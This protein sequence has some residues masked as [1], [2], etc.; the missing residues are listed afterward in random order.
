MSSVLS[1]TS[2]SVLADNFQRLCFMQVEPLNQVRVV[3][4]TLH[5]GMVTSRCLLQ[6][7]KLGRATLN[8]LVS[9]NT[10]TL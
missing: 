2:G 8:V 5:V 1:K 9:T 10:L 6:F 7:T 4:V 3:M